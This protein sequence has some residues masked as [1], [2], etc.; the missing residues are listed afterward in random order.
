MRNSCAE[1]GV[2]EFR[3]ET[4]FRGHARSLAKV[5]QF[6]ILL[7]TGAMRTLSRALAPATRSPITKTP[8]LHFRQ[9]NNVRRSE[10][11]RMLPGCRNIEKE[12]GERTQLYYRN[13]TNLSRLRCIEV[14]TVP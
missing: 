1:C 3:K 10:L 2:E 8:K 6:P 12:S 14:P 11:E 13:L 4:N 9:S 7:M 5:D